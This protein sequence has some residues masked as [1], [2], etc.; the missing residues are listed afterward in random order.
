MLIYIKDYSIK[1]KKLGNNVVLLKIII[2]MTN[3]A[4]HNLDKNNVVLK[5][6]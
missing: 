1:K 3:I 6:N 5:D 2:I 4:V